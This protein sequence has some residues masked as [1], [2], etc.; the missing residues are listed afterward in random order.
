MSWRGEDSGQREMGSEGWMGAGGRAGAGRQARKKQD[1]GKAIHQ[2]AQRQ[3]KN[4]L[5]KQIQPKRGAFLEIG[6][7]AIRTNTFD[8][9]GIHNPRS[10]ERSRTKVGIGIDNFGQSGV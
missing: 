6:I 7:S 10:G 9:V 5:E 2:R 1:E 4:C 8:D 3:L